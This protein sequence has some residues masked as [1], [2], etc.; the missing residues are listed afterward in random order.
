MKFIALLYSCRESKRKTPT[1]VALRNDER[2]F[3]DPA[4]AMVCVYVHV[5]NVCSYVWCVQV[6]VL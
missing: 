4:Y 5:C 3:G 6:V 1:V 2:L